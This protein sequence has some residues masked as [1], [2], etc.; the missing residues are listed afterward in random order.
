MIL[1]LFL[2]DNLWLFNVF[3]SPILFFTTH[4][5]YVFISIFIKL[6][7]ISP[8]LFSHCLSIYPRTF[9]YHITAPCLNCRWVLLCAFIKC[10]IFVCTSA[11]LWSY[12][13]S[14]ANSI[15][16]LY[17]MYLYVYKIVDNSLYFFFQMT[18]T[19]VYNQ[20]VYIYICMYT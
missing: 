3:P 15:S 9:I 12:Y 6:H 4:N 10:F 2:R 7:P 5:N 8:G 13:S 1:W 16:V 17:R 11:W 18:Y 19:Y 14:N 20:R